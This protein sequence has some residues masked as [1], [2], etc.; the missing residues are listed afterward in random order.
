MNCPELDVTAILCTYNRAEIFAEMLKTLAA[1]ELPDAIS[2]E[3]LVVDN[4][5]TDRTREVVEDFCRRYPGR[6]RYLFEPKPGKSYAL[7]AGIANA[8]GEVL[9]FVDDDV[10]VE[11]KWLRNLTANLLGGEWAGTVG[12]ILPA[13][14]VTLPAWLLWKDY[15]DAFLP[16]PRGVIYAYFDLG[17]HP[18]ELS[19]RQSQHGANMA[20]RRRMFEKY[21]GFRT[22][23]GPSQPT[24]TP[25]G[26]DTEFG[27]R[28]I[29]AGER[30]RYEPSA[31]V[32][33]AVT[34]N[35]FKKEYHLSWWFNFGR[36]S[37]MQRGD[38][39]GVYG[40]P[41]DYLSLLQRLMEI[42]S[43]GLRSILATPT[44]KRFFCKCMIRMQAGMMVELYRRLTRRK[45]SQ[46]AASSK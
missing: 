43:M 3:V 7:N 18:T 12:R 2:W 17:D 44:G 25:Q 11:P 35:R 13:Q 36:S 45:V 24:G 14:T 22:D 30:M 6:F 27:H 5:S 33:H 9:A 8:L 29:K 38:R 39:P 10:L 16:D 26:E 32:Y 37:I 31:V 21:G 42:S 23:L 19:L 20:F 46:A 15:G 34:Q 28:L 41:W 40:V 1:S 4:N